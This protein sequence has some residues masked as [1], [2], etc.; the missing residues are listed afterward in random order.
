[1]E[2]PMPPHP[3][4]PPRRVPDLIA[5]VRIPKVEESD[6]VP[7]ADPKTVQQGFHTRPVEKPETVKVAASPASVKTKAFT[8][9]E[10]RTISWGSQYVTLHPGDKISEEAYGANY[11]EKMRSQGVKLL[12]L[13]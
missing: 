2:T 9:A 7:S 4:Q 8:V 13:P 11:E 12:E 6:P 5:S 1:M 3:N 10:K